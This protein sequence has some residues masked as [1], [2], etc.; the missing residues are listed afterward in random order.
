ME[1]EPQLSPGGLSHR[2]PE[3]SFTTCQRIV[4]QDRGLYLYKIQVYQELLPH[5]YNKRVDY[6]NWFNN[7]MNNDEIL[8]R[9][10]YSDE[11][12]F[13]LSGVINTQ[14]MR[15]WSADSNIT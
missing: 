4:R 7:M 2:A 13:H 6:C 10:F 5:D 11:A 8:D 12:W 1:D 3:V 9:T 14:T 15:M